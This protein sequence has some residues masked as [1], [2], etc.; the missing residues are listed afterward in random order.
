MALPKGLREFDDTATARDN[1]Y[2]GVLD[3]V[4]KRFPYED[5]DFKLELLNPAY[6][7]KMDFGLSDQKQAL[8]TRRSL[9]VPITGTWRLTDKKTGAVEERQDTVMQVPYY[10]DRGTF[11]NNGSEYSAISQARLRPGVYVRRKRTGEIE[12]QFNVESGKGR[13]FR[14]SLEPS[15]GILKFNVAQ[16]QIPAYPVLKASGMTDAELDEAL[17][18]ELAAANRNAKAADAVSKFYAKMAGKAAV[19]VTGEESAAVHV[20]DL[21]SASSVDPDVL[22]RNLG[23]KGKSGIDSEVLRRAAQKMIA[24]SRG[25]EDQDDRDAPQFKEYLGVE[26]LLRERVDKDAGRLLRQL[27]FKIRRSRSLKSVPRSA[28][29]PYVNSFMLGSG[30][31]SPLEESNPLHYLEQMYRVS[32]FGEG[33]IG[34]SEAVTDDAREINPNQLGFLGT[35]EGPES[36]KIGVDARFAYDT[37]KGDDRRIY[38]RFKDVRTGKDLFLRPDQTYGMTL[39]FSNALDSD[40]ETVTAIRRGKTVTVPKSEL[41]IVLPSLARQFSQGVNL[42]SMPTG[43]QGG[44]QFYAAKFWTQYLPL[45]E[46][47][48]PLVDSLTPD[49]KTTFMEHYGRRSGT[50]KSPVEGT[51]KRV[52]ENSITVTGTDGSDVTVELIKDLPFNRMTSISFSASVKPGDKVE[53][54]GML[55]HSNYTDP[56]TGSINFGRNLKTATIPARGWSNDDSAVISE[57]AAQKLA[58]SRLYGFDLE[59]RH[60][61]ELGRDKYMSLFPSKFTRAQAE[62]LDENGVVKAGTVLNKGDPIIVGVGPRLLTAA[63]AQ[64]GKLHKALRNSFTDKAVVWEHEYPGTVTDSAMIRGNRGAAVNVKAEPPVQVG[65]KLCL[66]YDH[67]V[68][69]AE[70]WKRFEEVKDSD[71]V[72]ALDPDTGVFE[73]L[74]PDKVVSYEH[75]GDM[76]EIS[77][78]NVDLKATLNHMMYVDTG[79][80]FGLQRADSLY[81][82]PARYKKD[83]IWN[84]NDIIGVTAHV[85][86]RVTDR[87]AIGADAYMAFLGGV[88]GGGAWFNCD[89]V[90]SITVPEDAKLD[91]VLRDLEISGTGHFDA[92]GVSIRNRVLW[93]HFRMLGDRKRIPQWVFTL[94][95]RHLTVLLQWITGFSDSSEPVSKFT[96][97]KDLADDIQ[98]LCLHTGNGSEIENSEQGYRVRIW[99]GGLNPEAGPGKPVPYTG[100][101][102]CVSLPKYHVFMVRRNGKP[103][104]TGN[105]TSFAVKGVVGKIVPDDKM[106][107][108]AATN[109][110]YEI[111]FNPAAILSRVSPN[112]L[113]WMGL[114]KAAKA[115][116][117]Q[118]RIPQQRPKEGWKAWVEKTMAE[119]GVKDTADIFDPETGKT[120]KDIGDGYAYVHAFHHLS[121]KKLS[122]RGG[123]GAYDINMQPAKGGYEG[124]KRWSGLDVG[125]ALSHG[126]TAVLKDVFQIRGS[127]NENF[128]KALRAGQPLSDPGVPFIYEKFLNTLKAGGI[129]VIDNGRKT[130]LLPMTDDA[131]LKT[132]AKEIKSSAMLDHDFTPRPGGLFD[133]G[134]TGGTA[135]NKWAYIRLPEPVPNPVMEEPIRRVLGLT[136]AGLRDIIAG[137]ADLD[138]KTGGEAVAAA[139]SGIDMDAE[140]A[141]LREKVKNSRGSARDGA[142]KAIGYLDGARRQGLHPGQWM[143]RNVPVLPPVF[144]PISRMGDMGLVTDLNEL[145]RDLIEIKDGA[146][147]LRQEAGPEAAAEDRLTVYDAV[148]AVYGLGDPVTH[149]GK[150]KR[151]KG[152]IWQITGDS[153]KFG[154]VQRSVLSKTVDAVARGVITPDPQLDMDHIGIPEDAAWDS[155]KDFVIRRLSRKGY[156]LLKATEMVGNR[157]PVAKAALLD[158]MDDRPVVV[159]RAPTWHKF[160]LMGF[161]PVLA[162]GNTIRV[163]PLV[164]KGFNADFNGDSVLNPLVCCCISGEIHVDYMANLMRRFVPDYVEER[165]VDVFGKQTTIFCLE[166][167][168]MQVLGI[169]ADGTTGFVDV[170]NVSVHTSHGPDCYH[171]RTHN[172]MDAVF[173]AH[174]NFWKFD[175]T[176]AMVP[177]KTTDVG[178]GILV[179]HAASFELPVTEWNPGAPSSFEPTFENGFWFGHLLGDGTVTGRDDTISHCSTDPSTLDYLERVG[180]GIITGVDPWRE[181]NGNSTRWTSKAW[182]QWVLGFGK[183]A[184]GKL[185]QPWMMGG[186]LEFVKGMVAGLLAAEGNAESCDFRIEMI[187]R[188]LLV[189]LKFLLQSMGCV[190]RLSEGKPARIS[191]RTGAVCARTYVL[192]INTTTLAALDIPWPDT[193]KCD[194]FKG[195]RVP[196]RANWD[197][198]P[199]PE[200][201]SDL[202]RTQGKLFEGGR[203]RNSGILRDAGVKIPDVKQM[204]VARADGYCTRAFAEKVITGY[205][206][207][208]CDSDIARRW[209]DIVRNR[210]MRWDRITV[211][212]K[213]DRPDVTYDLRVPGMDAFAVD[214]CYLTHNTM[215]FHVPVSDKAKEEVKEKMLPSKNLFSTTDL[216]SP[217]HTPRM[218]M[219]MGLWMLSREP[220]PGTAPVKFP[221]AE[222]AMNA[223]RRGE[224]KANTPVEIAGA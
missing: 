35:I 213:C 133:P 165:A 126:A 166:K 211:Y 103:V 146:K 129:N 15:T 223:Y 33:G 71:T 148:K 121:E 117:K 134:I 92:F 89:N 113:L 102:W 216:R 109:E 217:Q 174:H 68:L 149:E 55:A 175:D 86:D 138:G 153:P 31:A 147:R 201:V 70:G 44:R 24:V 179:P 95:R 100:K 203:R 76:Y 118:I 184:G 202:C 97:S 111:L 150:S 101:V 56:K 9:N 63:D 54:G 99:R 156:P 21:L 152:A 82:K 32:G 224:L 22:E 169:K 11:I 127:K 188:Q 181:G 198:V 48:T 151:L 115:S 106:P 37:Y 142:V 187:N 93:G 207:N 139:L 221:D 80:G 206:L 64:L 28:L 62:T 46:G 208:R 79:T 154:L 65:D 128:W 178:I 10:T 61:V 120:I 130:S 96:D 105:S 42:N 12:T 30:L 18:P 205:G 8:I 45:K 172:G 144:R 59:A 104:W 171:V 75:D 135:G 119:H 66:S 67:E 191:K 145:Y 13:G 124:A 85:S 25:E 51:V 90:V 69:T 173:T 4:S 200:C 122:A 215:S 81:G 125:A 74:R 132:G 194:Q 57:T 41:D 17:G 53:K 78:P 84:G 107:R 116:G 94:S 141:R 91:E 77:T 38:G 158:E 218:E 186:G 123:G 114:A 7:K 47:E 183:N 36:E 98:T 143:I 136:Q 159:D 167:S 197:L 163:S 168:A 87:V 222:S 23:L 196:V 73:Y 26:D 40:S 220:D 212:E 160:N 219:T 108:D 50:L 157:D 204:R 199:F 43:M 20:R 3:A 5:D 182:A 83:G 19:P 190:C 2:S 60:G 29:T 1:I 164:T 209:V 27:M 185:F 88:L 189:Q 140:I 177:C 58:T 214:G 162:E 72:A 155:Y 39:G 195:A 49:G 193:R 192:R 180:A 131:V 16:S 112:Q 210:S 14:M 34:S 161:H 170:E 52:D 110:P 137:R 176:C 6:P